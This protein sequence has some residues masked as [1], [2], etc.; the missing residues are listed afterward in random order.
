M[1]DVDIIFK[2]EGD[3]L[4]VIFNTE[5]SKQSHVYKEVHELEFFNKQSE[6][7]CIAHESKNNMVAALIG[8]NLTSE[9]F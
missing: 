4:S 1:R 3:Y 7:F 5:K 6:S 2:D 8:H 9:S